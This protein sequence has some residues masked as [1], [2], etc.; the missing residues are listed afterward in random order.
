MATKVYQYPKC[1]TC[2]QALKWL[3]EHV[4]G[5]PYGVDVVMPASYEGSGLDVDS[6]ADLFAALQ[7]MIPE[8]HRTF[9]ENLLAKH[10]VR[11]ASAEGDAGRYLLGWI[12]ATGRPQV[13]VAL[14]H[15]IALLAD[16]LGPPPADVVEQAHRRGVAMAALASSPR[17]ADK[18]VNAGVDI[19][20]AQGTE[21]G[22]HTGVVST[23]VVVPE[24]VDAVAP[25]PVLAAGALPMPLQFMLISDALRRVSTAAAADLAAMPVGQIVGAMNKVKPA[26]GVAMGS[27]TVLIVASRLAAFGWPCG[28]SSSRRGPMRGN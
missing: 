8:G 28:R 14:R 11:S 9:V 27:A 24:I 19:I 3:D 4:E 10:G 1:S 15:P 22:G 20:V 7:R 12:D 21:A 16:A 25:R 26:R 23:M 6:P 18:Q 2:R 5:R 17:H 13:E